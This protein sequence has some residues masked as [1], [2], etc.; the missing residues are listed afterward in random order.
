MDD[1]DFVF[2]DSPNDPPSQ[3]DLAKSTI[4][5]S[6]DAISTEMQKNLT[7]KERGDYKNNSSTLCLYIQ[8]LSQV[9]ELEANTDLSEEMKKNQLRDIIDATKLIEYRDIQEIAKNQGFVVDE[10]DNDE[11]GTPTEIDNILNGKSDDKKT[12]TN[13]GSTDF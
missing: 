10:S 1:E 3:Y 12:D 6:I 4:L 9:E 5:K 7:Y 2:D 11:N 8:R 13:D